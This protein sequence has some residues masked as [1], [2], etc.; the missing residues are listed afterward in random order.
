MHTSHD[1]RATGFALT[2]DGEPEPLEALWPGYAGDR[3][4]LAVVLGA[5]LD[6]AACATLVVATTT[7]FYEDL[8]AARGPAGFFRYPDTFLVGVGEYD[9]G[10]RAAQLEDRFLQR[11]S[12]LLGHL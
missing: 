2:R 6:A 4:R 11:P 3:D 8:R 1:L 12:A 10:V 9:E 7:L 5:P